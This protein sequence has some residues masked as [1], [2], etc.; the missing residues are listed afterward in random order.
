MSHCD[1]Y[2]TALM[3]AYLVFVQTRSYEKLSGGSAIPAAH[4]YAYVMLMWQATE[5][6]EEEEEGSY[7]KS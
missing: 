5:E 3:Y 6:E 7:L 1:S 4:C 2:T